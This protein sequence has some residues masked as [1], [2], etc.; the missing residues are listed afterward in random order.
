MKAQVRLGEGG[1]FS[2]RSAILLYGCNTGAAREATVATIHPVEIDPVGRPTILAGVTPDPAAVQ[3]TLFAMLG[4]KPAGLLP[5]NLLCLTLNQM[6]WFRPAAPAPIWFKVTRGDK[7]LEKISGEIVPQP[8]L[9]FCA[10]GTSVYVFA[11][12]ENKRPDAH[13][14]LMRAPYYNISDDGD[15]CI[16][17]ALMPSNDLHP[18]AIPRYERGF[19]ESKFTHPTGT[20]LS[21]NPGGHDR[22]WPALVGKKKFPVQ[23]LLPQPRLRQSSGLVTLAD[24]LRHE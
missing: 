7:A 10:H 23:H 8:P 14:V 9:L 19:F 4:R 20:K 12:A 22:L 15:L 5:V 13:T 1:V 6:I 3:A 17:S 16:G 21:A 18:D 11:L 2:L 24:L